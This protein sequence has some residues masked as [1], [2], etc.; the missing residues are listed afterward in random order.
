LPK[1]FSPDF[2]S[3]PRHHCPPSL[4]F[5]HAEQS[6]SMPNNLPTPTH[7]SN[8]PLSPLLKL[9]QTIT[10]ALSHPPPKHQ[11]TT[12]RPISTS[13]SPKQTTLH[14]PRTRPSYPTPSRL[15]RLH[16]RRHCLETTVS[17]I[18]QITEHKTTWYL[19]RI[20]RVVSARPSAGSSSHEHYLFARQS[21]CC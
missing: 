7:T 4:Y 13:P 2:H 15:T 12:K 21:S 17:A 14:N 9:I 6:S 11:R 19:S 3:T 20:E 16:H 5:V 18:E 10:Y 8:T 1:L